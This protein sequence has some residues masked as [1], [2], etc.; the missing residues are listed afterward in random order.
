M[1]YENLDSILA[2]TAKGPVE[3]VEKQAKAP[4]IMDERYIRHMVVGMHARIS[5]LKQIPEWIEL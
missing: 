2:R 5:V 3:L 4:W 1:L